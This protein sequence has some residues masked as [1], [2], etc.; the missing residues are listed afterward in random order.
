MT[1]NTGVLEG[2]TFM[3]GRL[4]T[5]LREGVSRGHICDSLYVS[6][7]RQWLPALP[8]ISSTKGAGHARATYSR[9]CGFLRHKA[10]LVKPC[11]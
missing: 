7:V 9:V 3:V 1:A 4:S 2:P 8:A 6:A 10:G 11:Q 5:E